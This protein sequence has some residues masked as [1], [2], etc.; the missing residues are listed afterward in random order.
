LHW[1]SGAL[2]AAGIERPRREARLLL[3][4]ALGITLE[5][6]VRDPGAEF[7]RVE[8]EGLIHRRARREPLAH[9]VGRRGFWTLDLAVSRAALIPRPETET[10]IDAALAAFPHRTQVRTVL[11]L[12]TGTG[13]LLL[14]ALTEFTDAFGIG[15]DL[16]PEAAALAAANARRCGLDR[17]A[18]F[19][20][21]NWATPIAGRF[22]LVLS[23]PPYI[24]S[25]EIERLSPEVALHDPR[26][27][28]DGGVDGL[29]SYRRLV[30]SLPALLTQSGVAVLELGIGQLDEVARM[31]RN[32]GL[33]CSERADLAGLPRALVLRRAHP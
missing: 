9:I 11:D 24:V 1:A 29:S 5:Q 17:R 3:A 31:A 21:A 7:D 4:H 15:A 13:C 22:D 30:P 2:A 25:S 23:N 16:A 14:A 27:A 28:L 18:T 12:G 26:G 19:L 32:V 20:T 10:L 8:Y 6:L 33:A